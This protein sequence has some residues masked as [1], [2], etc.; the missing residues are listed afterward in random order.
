[1]IFLFGPLLVQTTAFAFFCPIVGVFLHFVSAKPTLGFSM[2]S[3]LRMYTQFPYAIILLF[4][5]SDICKRLDSISL[6]KS[7][8]TSATSNKP[9]HPV[10]HRSIIP[11]K[12]ALLSCFSS[13]ESVLTHFAYSVLSIPTV[14]ILLVLHSSADCATFCFQE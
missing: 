12:A 7:L 10:Q 9:K 1:M 5:E 11:T 6:Q 4:G 13:S 14:Y 8:L 3:I 2:I